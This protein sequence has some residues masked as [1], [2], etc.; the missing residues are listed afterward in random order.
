[1]NLSVLKYCA[2][3]YLLLAGL[4]FL[5]I[6]GGRS[7][8]AALVLLGGVIVI[9]VVGLLL[10]MILSALFRRPRLERVFYWIRQAVA[11]GLIAVPV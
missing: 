5:G 9:A 11:F 10:G 8:E 2:P 6:R 4:L 7:L 1:M 3:L